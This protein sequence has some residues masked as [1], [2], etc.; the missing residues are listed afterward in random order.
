[1]A[2]TVDI[3][4]Q[5]ECLRSRLANPKLYNATHENVQAT[6]QYLHS[7]LE[8]NDPEYRKADYAMANELVSINGTG[9]FPIDGRELHEKLKI[10]TAY[11]VWFA[12]MCEYG[13]EENKDFLTDSKNVIR[14]DGIEMPQ[15]QACHQLTLSMAKE[16]CMLQRTEQG[17]AVR[18]YLI[19]VEEDWNKPESVMARALQFMDI[20]LKGLQG[21]MLHLQA[22]NSEL[23]VNNQIDNKWYDALYSV[24]MEASKR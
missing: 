9:N 1:M 17:R 12:R 8:E 14:A 15:K 20:K 4:W 13:F 19:S 7:W 21:D 23:V 16:I 6:V 18:R 24:G 3:K 5:R 10:G 11:T 2:S 22:V